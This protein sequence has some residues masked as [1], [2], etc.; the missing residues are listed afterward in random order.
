MYPDMPWMVSDDSSLD[1]IRGNI[2]Q[3]WGN[4]VA[5]RS[6]LFAFGYDACQLMLALS[7]GRQKLAEVQIAG[8]SGQLHFDAQGRVQRE[9]I[10][11][12]LRDGEPKRLTVSTGDPPQTGAISPPTRQ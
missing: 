4:G 7:G 8:L 12:Q 5:W 9:L 6:R 3:A 1:A 10:W 11:V 2:E